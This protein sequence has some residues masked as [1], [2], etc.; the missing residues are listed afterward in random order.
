[1]ATTP[2]RAMNR[3]QAQKLLRKLTGEA[4]AVQVSLRVCDEAIYNID[5]GDLPHVLASQD[6]CHCGASKSKSL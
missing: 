1:M 6:V 5:Q 4:T 2:L 3:P